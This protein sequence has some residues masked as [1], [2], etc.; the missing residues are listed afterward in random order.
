LKRHELTLEQKVSL[1]ND[2]SDG[3]GLSIR[4]LAEKYVISTSGVANIL[5]RRAEYQH[6]YKTNS[7]KDSERKLR[8][9]SGKHIDQIDFEW[10]TAQRA[11]HIPI[12]GPLLQEK[13]R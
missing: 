11:K 4:K 12:S 9:E 1:I 13:A 7:N 2:N 6:D 3:N 10:F 5:T 8:D